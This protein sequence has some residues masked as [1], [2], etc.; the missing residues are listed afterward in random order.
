MVWETRSGRRCIARADIQGLFRVLTDGSDAD[1]LTASG[2]LIQLGVQRG[3]E[4]LIEL[5]GTGSES[6]R[7]AAA[8]KFGE[9]REARAV[10]ALAVS[11]DDPSETVM[12]AARQAL[13]DIDTVEA[14][15]VLD[16][17]EADH[18]EMDT[19]LEVL[20]FAYDPIMGSNRLPGERKALNPEERQTAAREEFV[21]ANS[22]QEEGRSQEALSACDKVL[23][24]DPT[25]ADALNL[26]GILHEELKQPF[27]ALNDYRKA[28]LYDSTLGEARTNLDDLIR[29]LDLKNV[30]V[31][32]WVEQTQSSTWEERQ[33]A[34]IALS[35][36]DHPVAFRTLLKGLE[37]E[38]V[39]VITAVIEALE[40]IDDPQSR[41]ALE[42][43]YI[44][45]GESG[46][47]LD[48]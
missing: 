42:Q 21:L 16:E 25:W 3:Y 39:E 40:G 22:Y 10:D 12:E 19:D 45:M 17:W 13:L 47:E 34:Y 35:F 2:M 41:Q 36:S 33:A 48:I 15:R 26:R 1:Q 30:N 20:T 24:V 23:A 38:D 27:L 7:A 29:E 32:E 31:S 14:K 9:L 8:E 43:Y 37:D 44:G 46:A 28:Y 11:M 6:V 5:L 18:S 4:H